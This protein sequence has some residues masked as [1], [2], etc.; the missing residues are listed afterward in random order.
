MQLARLLTV[1]SKT[2]VTVSV[3]GGHQTAKATFKVDFHSILRH[4]Q[5]SNLLL[6]K[7]PIIGWE[8]VALAFKPALRRH[9]Q[10]DL[11]ELE[12]NLVYRV[13][14]G[15]SMLF[16]RNLVLKIQKRKNNKSK[17]AIKINPLIETNSGLLQNHFKSIK[18]IQHIDSFTSKKLN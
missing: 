6:Y 2:Y 8:A 17:Q 15:Q 11:C 13:S 12:A 18:T 9:R 16:C 1:S 10:G 5:I 14:S 7:K 3:G 4:K